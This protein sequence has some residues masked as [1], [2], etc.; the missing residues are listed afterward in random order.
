MSA[1]DTPDGTYDPE[2]GTLET[3]EDIRH[4]DV[5]AGIHR[6]ILARERRRDAPL[7]EDEA[8]AMD[9]LLERLVEASVLFQDVAVQARIEDDAPRPAGL[10]FLAD[11]MHRDTVRAY[12]L[13]HG[14]PPD[15]A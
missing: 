2:D 14:Y 6:H 12:R 1:P 10:T 11:A 7:T 9:L 8:G 15:D 3:R 5:D 4:A 13:F